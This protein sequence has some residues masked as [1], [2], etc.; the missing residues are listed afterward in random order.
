MLDELQKETQ[1]L[2]VQ[3][4]D[5]DKKTVDFKRQLEKIENL[6]VRIAATDHI[7]SYDDRRKNMEKLQAWL[8]K[9]SEFIDA[10]RLI[11]KQMEE[12]AAWKE[13][14]CKVLLQYVTIFFER[15]ESLD[16]TSGNIVSQI[17]NR[18]NILKKL[19]KCYQMVFQVKEDLI[20]ESIL[21]M[22]KN[23]DMS[24]EEY[25]QM[26][27]DFFA[28]EEFQKQEMMRLKEEEE[29]EEKFAQKVREPIVT[30]TPMLDV[31]IPDFLQ[32]YIDQ[33][34]QEKIF[35]RKQNFELYL[36][37]LYRQ[38]DWYENLKNTDPVFYENTKM[39]QQMVAEEINRLHTVSHEDLENTK[40]DLN[41]PAAS[42]DIYSILQYLVLHK[43]YPKENL[44]LKEYP[45][46]A[47]KKIQLMDIRRNKSK[48]K[49]YSY[50]RRTLPN[51]TERIKRIRRALVAAALL[52]TFTPN[53][54]TEAFLSNDLLAEAESPIDFDYFINL[55]D[56]IVLNSYT[57]F[58]YTDGFADQNK[59]SVKKI[60]LYAPDIPRTVERLFLVR[61]NEI[62]EVHSA[63]E[64]NYY[65]ELGYVPF[66][67]GTFDGFY[68][69][70]D[71][72]VIKKEKNLS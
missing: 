16:L 3:N 65:L 1:L 15:K 45:N 23:E 22:K 51:I 25:Q 49:P 43:P 68:K 53:L 57:V 33:S 61:D 21:P 20:S 30:T 54:E 18:H 5:P 36:D 62:I 67:V 52:V 17:T 4:K 66:S 70:S 55:G 32:E 71:V 37:K 40:K 39:E 72:T 59:E 13:K 69:V 28:R 10:C 19:N 63:S 27:R 64:R 2:L 58:S 11:Y 44:V 35:E 7:E 6:I 24:L 48:G 38:M 9:N 26:V 8:N 29:R 42:M 41:I 60:P 46:L 12:N 47:E 56:A 34:T 31:K 50:K 14:E